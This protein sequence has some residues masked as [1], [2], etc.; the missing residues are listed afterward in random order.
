MTAGAPS[1]PA[2]EPVD[3]EAL[4]ARL[5]GRSPRIALVLGSGLG[6]LAASIEDAIRIPYAEIPNFPQSA[7]TGH[8]GELVAGRLSG[9]EVIALSGR[10][11]YYETGDSAAMRPA[12]EALK[13][14]GI[15]VLV[16][17]NAA[18]SLKPELRPGDVM[19]I[20]DHIAFSGR[21]PLIGEPSDARFTGMTAAYDED[22]RAAMLAAAETED[23][24]LRS[25][26]YM[27][28]SGPSFE[29][30]AEVRVARLL[31]ADAVG[32]STVPET[33][34]ARFLGLKVVA[35][36]VVTNYGAGMTGAELSHEETKA[37]APTGG[38]TLARILKSAL[39]AFRA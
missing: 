32:M 28:F 16:L 1:G 29:T 30:P 31:G 21:N 22:L 13:G 27:W 20:E 39:P 26:V 17:T 35:A 25:G 15:R 33:I 10:V 18:G 5:G 9:V 24:K 34:L 19:L 12:L 11:H 23:V 6:A 4:R 14:L 37:V 38:A 36:S 8:S 3:V 2:P 7:V